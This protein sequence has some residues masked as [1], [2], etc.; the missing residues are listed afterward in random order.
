MN[1]VALRLDGAP[2]SRDP[3]GMAA[4]RLRSICTPSRPTK[5]RSETC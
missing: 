2:G 3:R 4:A 5:L 1:E